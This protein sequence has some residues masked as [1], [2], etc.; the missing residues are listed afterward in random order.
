MQVLDRK[1]R[2][3][4]HEVYPASDRDTDN[5]QALGKQD[6]SFQESRK[7]CTQL[8]AMPARPLPIENSS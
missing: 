4:D 1:A 5:E 2:Q 3:C 6:Y 7:K 8:G